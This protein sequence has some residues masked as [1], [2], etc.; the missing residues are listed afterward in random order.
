M[1]ERCPSVRQ[2]RPISPGVKNTLSIIRK[3]L[4]DR[5]NGKGPAPEI[6]HELRELLE[7][8][9]QPPYEL[10]GDGRNNGNGDGDLND[11]LDRFD[12]DY[13]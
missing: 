11:G 1:V 3:N 2:T 10:Y 13:L 6:L 12:E 4:K 7:Q 9:R 8:G 5:G